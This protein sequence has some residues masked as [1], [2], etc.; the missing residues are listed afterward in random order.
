MKLYFLHSKM[1]VHISK[2]CS[3]DDLVVLHGRFRSGTH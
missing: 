2:D 3:G 1:Q